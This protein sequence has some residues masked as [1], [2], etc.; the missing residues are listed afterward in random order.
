LFIAGLPFFLIPDSYYPNILS[1]ILIKE[2]LFLISGL[3][4]ILFSKYFSIYTNINFRISKTLLYYLTTII[5]TL[6]FCYILY[7]SGAID[8]NINE[9]S[10]F[11][12]FGGF[13][14]YCTIPTFFTG[15]GEEIIFRWFLINRLRTFLNI[16][17]T[18]V[19]SSLIFCIGHNWNIPNMLF[20]FTGGC[21][22]G[23]IYI[24]TDS[25]FNCIGIHSAWNF[26]Q[27]FFFEGMSEFTY[28]AQRLFLFEIKDL[29]LYNW[30]EFIFCL[31]ILSLFIIMYPLKDRKSTSSISQRSGSL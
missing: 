3:I 12:S 18:I 23:L 29:S 24:R 16:N 19:I 31:L 17:T 2:S 26:G 4:I 13:L 22:F 21:L 8:V 11:S 6:V 25:V 15:F 30:Y 27:R 5:I 7:L 9:I 14:I 10:S 1:S 28:K 20:A